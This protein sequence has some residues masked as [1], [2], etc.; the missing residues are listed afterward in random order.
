MRINKFWRWW[1]QNRSALLLALLVLG[2]AVLVK[3]THGAGL[4][5]LRRS[6][7]GPFQ[8]DGSKQQVLIDAQTQA[9]QTQVQELEGQNQALR[10]LLNLSPLPGYRKVAAPVVARSGDS[11]WQQLTLGKGSVDGIQVDAVVV[12]PGGLVGRVMSV[13]PTTCRVLLVSDPTSKIGVTVSRSRQ[14]GILSGR[15]NRYGVVE[16]EN[17][18]KTINI[19]L[20]DAVVT[21]TLSSRFPPGIA[22]GR[23]SELHLDRRP[24]PQAVVEFTVPIETVEWVNVLTNG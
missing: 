10:A 8:S 13:S 1:D 9:L 19:K 17:F 18:E 12:A 6:I 21:S 24:I 23:V 22:I 11:W 7:A 16:F 20:N 5:D 3:V 2:I 15:L 14:E 4:L